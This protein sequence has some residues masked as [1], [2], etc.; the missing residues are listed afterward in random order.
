VRFTSPYP[1]DFTDDVIAAIA[2]EPKVC[3]HVHL[4]LQSGTDTVLE[5]MRRGYDTAGFLRIVEALRAGIPGVA[6]ST[7][8][9]AGFSGETDADFEQTLDLMRR[10]KFDD[11]FLFAYSEREGTLAERKL[12]DDVPEAV[13]KQR[14]ALAIVVQDEHSAAARQARIGHIERVLLHDVSRRSDEQ[15]LGRTDNSFAVI[16]PRGDRA[17]G[18]TVTARI[19]RA[20]NATLFG[21]VIR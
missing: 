9:L 7:D 17:P 2:E 20:T 3:K 11:A 13:K 19:T 15:L 18:Q 16:V 5:R 4:P 6:I 12:P 1:I 8:I 10:V 14:L 21:D